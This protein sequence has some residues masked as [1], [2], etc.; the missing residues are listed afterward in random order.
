MDDKKYT[1]LEHSIRNVVRES[2]GVSG[3]DKF[4]GAPKPFLKPAPHIEPP[5][6]DEHPDASNVTAQRGAAKFKTSETMKEEEQIDE[7]G[8]IDFNNISPKKKEEPAKSDNVLLKN[9]LLKYGSNPDLQYNRS[10]KQKSLAAH[11]KYQKDLATGK[12]N[13]LPSDAAATATPGGTVGY[14]VSKAVN[15]ADAFVRGAGNVLGG[16]IVAGAANYIGSKLPGGSDKGWEGSGKE[17]EKLKGQVGKQAEI[18]A[19]KE[20]FNPAEYQAGTL[21]GVGLS[22]GAGELAGMKGASASGETSAVAGAAT[23]L[24]KVETPK[25][26]KLPEVPKATETPEVPK[27]VEEPKVQTPK[28]VNKTISDIMKRPSDLEAPANINTK[29][30]SMTKVPGVKVQGGGVSTVE[31]PKN[32]PAGQ[33]NDNVPT[34]KKV[35]TPTR[36]EPPET[37]TGGKGKTANDAE[38]GAEGRQGANKVQLQ[39]KKADIPPT[40]EEKVLDKFGGYNKK[41]EN[42]KAPGNE[43]VKPPANDNVSA[44]KYKPPKPGNVDQAAADIIK[45]QVGNSNVKPPAQ[46]APAA[47]KPSK[48]V[49][50]PAAPRPA[51]TPAPAQPAPAPA[52]A[53][54]TKLAPAVSN[55]AAAPDVAQAPAPKPATNQKPEPKEKEEDKN[56]RKFKLPNLP[57]LKNIPTGGGSDY[58]GAKTY[59]HTA[60]GA[61]DYT[62]HAPIVREENDADKKRRTIENVARPGGKTRIAKQAEIK[63]KIVEENNKKLNVIRKAISDKKTKTSTVNLNP[64]LKH[65]ELDEH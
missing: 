46:P 18:S 51:A 4:K 55:P 58:I 25:T 26:T 43:N 36:V 3:T 28:S 41:P 47:P 60:P 35:E 17:W 31:A 38:A 16:D 9:P 34:P 11:I 2:I 6:G 29:T 10:L 19:G 49:P 12:A 24:P 65:P 21:A 7:A 40:P 48:T 59:M 5:K 27:T 20:K 30:T 61:A 14:E 8:V 13:K 64:K 32:S 54:A 22:V 37:P 23:K 45:K 33:F 57:S 44:P 15:K 52:A 62:Y 1:S 56:K 63:A 50:A 53:P 42:I 39:P